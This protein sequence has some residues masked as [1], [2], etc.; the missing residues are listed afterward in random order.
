MINS[1]SIA[2][3]AVWAAIQMPKTACPVLSCGG[4]KGGPAQQHR[5]NERHDTV[6]ANA[7][8]AHDRELCLTIVRAA[9]PI[10]EV[11]QPIIM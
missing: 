7:A 8:V 4:P 5:E 3:N 9:E 6:G 2:L 11:G 1:G 10:S